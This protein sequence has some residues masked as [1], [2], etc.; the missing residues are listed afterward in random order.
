MKDKSLENRCLYS[1]QEFNVYKNWLENKE[2]L[3]SLLEGLRLMISPHSSDKASIEG[4][5]EELKEWL[6]F[7]KKQEPERVSNILNEDGCIK[8]PQEFVQLLYQYALYVHPAINEAFLRVVGKILVAEI[9]AHVRVYYETYKDR[10]TW[11][12]AEILAI[13]SSPRRVNQ[14]R[15]F[16]LIKRAI[17][18]KSLKVI[19]TDDQNWQES[20]LEPSEFIDW[21][22]KNGMYYHF[23]P[24]VV[25]E[26]LRRKKIYY[27]PVLNELIGLSSEDT[28]APKKRKPGAHTISKE[29]V[30]AVAKELWLKNPT[31]SIAEM[32]KHPEI[33]EAG[34]K[35]YAGKNTLQNWLSAVDPRPKAQK[36]GRLSRG[37]YPSKT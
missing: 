3:L 33:L 20:P 27:H 23:E 7:A 18:A 26:W 21:K 35:N 11:T 8:N 32:K 16:E 9:N 14:P 30:Q 6:D 1:D 37:K 24:R 29:K 4:E 25:L 31:M 15:N 5:V 19:R 28:V 10:E 17:S 2:P 34:G 36:P 22:N 12:I 13:T